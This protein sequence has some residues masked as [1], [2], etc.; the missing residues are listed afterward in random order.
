MLWSASPTELARADALVVPGVGAFGACVRG[1][2]EAGGAD[3]ILGWL[4]RQRPLLGICVGHQVLFESGTEGDERVRGLGIFPGEVSQ[5]P[6]QRL[7]HMGWNQVTAP[8]ESRLFRS[9]AQER[10]YFVH[11][12]AAWGSLP[13]ALTSLTSH[14]GTEFIAALEKENVASTQFHPEK[15]G[16]AGA[17]LLRNWLSS[18]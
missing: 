4:E 14:E 16:A 18:S 8:P 11:S 2:R 10:F 13:Q 3:L 12:Y 9:I 5:L 15:S 6:T 7:P 17:K 1:L